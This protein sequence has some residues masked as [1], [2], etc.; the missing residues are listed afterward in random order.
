[1][2]VHER[3]KEKIKEYIK[4][5]RYRK[6]AKLVNFIELQNFYCRNEI[7]VAKI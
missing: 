5:I 7:F 1:V 3:K 6:M 4:Y 2:Q